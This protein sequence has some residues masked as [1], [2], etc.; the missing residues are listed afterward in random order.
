MKIKVKPK[1][2]INSTIK[3]HVSRMLETYNTNSKGLHELINHFIVVPSWNREHLKTDLPK[4]EKALYR[5]NRFMSTKKFSYELISVELIAFF[6]LKL[7]YFVRSRQEEID[8]IINAKIISNE[9]VF[10][11]QTMPTQ[12]LS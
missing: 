3:Q 12:R 7:F 5:H 10:E 1:S 6:N 4:A 11:I 8:L 2:E 9:W